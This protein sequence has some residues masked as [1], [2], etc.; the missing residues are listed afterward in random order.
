VPKVTFVDIGRTVEFESGKLPYHEHGKPES[1]LDVA[2]SV[3]E[4]VCTTCAV[5]IAIPT[6]ADD[7]P[8]DRRGERW[9]P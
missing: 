3:G 2:L 7:N 5:R 1:I 6:S 4:Q 8:W 9:N